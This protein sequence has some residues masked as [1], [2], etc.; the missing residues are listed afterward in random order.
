[1]N[2]HLRCACVSGVVAGKAVGVA[3]LAAWLLAAGSAGAQQPAN[4]SNDTAPAESPAARRAA[5]ETV[6]SEAADGDYQDALHDHYR[7]HFR[8]TL[9]LVVSPVSGPLAAHVPVFD[10]R[11]GFGLVVHYVAPESPAARA[12]IQRHTILAAIGNQRLYSVQQ[13]AR[14]LNQ[15]KP[16]QKVKVSLIQPGDNGRI[17]TK[18]MTVG[19]A[20][21]S[22]SSDLDPARFDPQGTPQGMSRGGSQLPGF[23]STGF[24][25][26]PPPQTWRVYGYRS[27][28]DPVQSEPANWYNTSDPSN[29]P[30]VFPD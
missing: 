29:E 20:E 22:T 4:V 24:Y 6:Q 18:E 28:D 16:G 8:P 7:P 17:T 10:G 11:P 30:L 26:Y 9:G 14:I 1:M 12:G 19:F 27:G 25:V 21:A 13:Y 3:V 15:L 23:G 5:A 2:Y